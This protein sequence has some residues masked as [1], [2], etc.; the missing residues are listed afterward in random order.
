MVY[1]YLLGYLLGV[2]RKLVMAFMTSK[3]TPNLFSHGRNIKIEVKK[4]I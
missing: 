4:V 1:L 2:F 3:N